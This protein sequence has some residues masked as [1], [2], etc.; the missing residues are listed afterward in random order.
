MSPAQ[1]CSRFAAAIAAVVLIAL[2]SGCSSDDEASK[3]TCGALPDELVDRLTGGVEYSAGGILPVGKG[4][5]T[6]E[7]ISK[8]DRFLVATVND[9]PTKARV[10]EVRGKL[11]KE[12]AAVKQRC[13]EA[14][15]V[16]EPGYGYTCTNDGEIL[17]GIVTKRQLIRFSL[18]SKRNPPTVEM[19]LDVARVIAGKTATG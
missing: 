1:R 11:S 9:L 3:L 2:S 13:D 5:G 19:A 17:V 15:I 6:C 7:I 4:W 8:G 16:D 18:L 12:R 14:T 10:E